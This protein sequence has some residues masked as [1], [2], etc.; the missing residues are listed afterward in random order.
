MSTHLDPA[1]ALARSVATDGQSH[2][3]YVRDMEW[4]NDP[5]TLRHTL[6]LLRSDYQRMADQYHFT[7]T[8]KRA[9]EM[10]FLPQIL[11]L[12][13]F[14]FSHYFLVSNFRSGAWLLYMVNHVLTGFDCI[15]STRIGE[16]CLLGHSVA[17]VLSGQIGRNATIFARA[18]TG[19][20]RDLMNIG[21]GPGL[22]VIGDNVTLGVNSTVMGSLFIGDGAFIGAHSLVMSDVPPDAVMIGVP[23]TLRRY[24]RDATVSTNS[25]ELVVTR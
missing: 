25:S 5:I 14:R 20:G 8:K 21:A 24:R 1:Q 3:E 19:G 2:P 15:P 16:R 22:P 4:L 12:I 11:A 23:A 17:T 13:V 9:L 7:L 10:T 18:G 6:R